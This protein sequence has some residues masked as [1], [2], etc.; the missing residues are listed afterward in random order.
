MKMWTQ[1]CL[2]FLFLGLG[3]ADDEIDVIADLKAKLKA[4][5]LDVDAALKAKIKI[6]GIDVDALVKAGLDEDDIVIIIAIKVE[7]ELPENFRFARTQTKHQGHGPTN[8]WKISMNSKVINEASGR[9]GTYVLDQRR[10][11]LKNMTGSAKFDDAP[12]P[13]KSRAA[14]NKETGIPTQ[15]R[16][17]LKG[18]RWAEYG[19]TYKTTDRRHQN[20]Y[21][22][23][24]ASPDDYRD[25]EH[26]YN[27]Y[28]DDKAFYNHHYN[29]EVFY[30]HHYDEEN[31]Y[32]D[33]DDG[34]TFYN[35][36]YEGQDFDTDYYDGALYLYNHNYDR[37][38]IDND[39]D[40][41]AFY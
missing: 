35:G 13:I 15:G 38:A 22:E 28:Y 7:I 21:H 32:N 3:L 30:N 1:L 8:S 41:E 24:E 12:S 17:P 37:E 16:L 2:I 36:Y 4:K 11:K 9:N 23:D 27:D 10:P 31:P 18:R 26:F 6:E 39:Y 29:E 5:G 33:H 19:S 20:D 34:E 14:G 40:D 25:S